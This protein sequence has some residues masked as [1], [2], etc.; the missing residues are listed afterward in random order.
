METNYKLYELAASLYKT[1]VF[2]MSY[3]RG[4]E[5][6]TKSL[7]SLVQNISVS[8]YQNLY[9]NIKCEQMKCKKM[10]HHTFSVI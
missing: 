2:L 10:H 7:F 3:K 4:V 9:G 1:I 5:H 8:V 6:N